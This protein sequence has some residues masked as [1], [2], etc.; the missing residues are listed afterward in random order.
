MDGPEW[1]SPALAVVDIQND[2]VDH[3]VGSCAI[4]TEQSVTRAGR[5]VAAASPCG[6]AR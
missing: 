3:D 2:F 6:S 1:G 4:G 5:V